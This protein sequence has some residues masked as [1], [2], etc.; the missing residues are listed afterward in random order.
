MSKSI[1]RFYSHLLVITIIID[2]TSLYQFI[3][4]DSIYT[5]MRIG[6]P[7]LLPVFKKGEMVAYKNWLKYL[8][9][10]Y[11]YISLFFLFHIETNFGYFFKFLVFFPILL[12]YYLCVKEKYRDELLLI[13]NSWITKIAV[14]SLLLYFLGP[15]TNIITPT[16]KVFTEWGIPRNVDTYFYLLFNTQSLMF[17]GSEMFRNT[18]IFTEGPMCNFHFC[19]ALLI[20]LYVKK[21]PIRLNVL[22]LVLGILSVFSTTGQVLLILILLSVPIKKIIT[23]KTKRIYKLIIFVTV[24]P[25]F[26]FISYWGISSIIMEKASSSAGSFVTH[27]VNMEDGISAFKNN[28]IVGGGIGNFISGS[29]NSFFVLLAEGGICLTLLY[30]VTFMFFPY[31]G[32]RNTQNS[33]IL[34]FSFFLFVL[35]SFT[36]VPY[37][38]ITFLCMAYS[39]SSVKR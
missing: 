1:I 6:I 29:S 25:I 31:L 12:Y 19:L 13:Y 21:K 14:V 9:I 18:S 30:V 4:P 5:L 23:L 22:V 27:L 36:V 17:M 38:M 20:E 26:L 24:V 33:N 32:Y 10:Y 15:L 3:I 37:A 28:P 7:M 8:V 34:L 16:G 39:F 11:L 2:Y 35:I